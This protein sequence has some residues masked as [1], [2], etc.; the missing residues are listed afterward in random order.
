MNEVGKYPTI[1]ATTTGHRLQ[2]DSGGQAILWKVIL[3]VIVRNTN[4]FINICPIPNVY[5]DSAV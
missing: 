2:G 1:K 4:I 5:G 3:S